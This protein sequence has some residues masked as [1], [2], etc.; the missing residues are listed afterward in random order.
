MDI[1]YKIYIMVFIF[2]IDLFINYK[3]D[4]CFKKLKGIK[5]IILCFNILVHSI[6]AS[7]IL[8]GWMFND[9]F[10]LKCYVLGISLAVILWIVFENINFFN[11]KTASCFISIL[12]N[13]LCDDK[14]S[15]PYKGVMHY[16]NIPNQL[17]YIMLSSFVI[18][19]LYKIYYV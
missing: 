15:V 11:E 1:N 7:M 14:L 17:N 16:L 5:Y 8:C 6:I 9:K 12:K 4:K 3:F 10:L 18:I 13:I 19:S 2:I